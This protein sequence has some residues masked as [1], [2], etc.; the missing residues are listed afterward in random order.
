QVL[1]QRMTSCMQTSRYG[2]KLD[3]S[4]VALYI[5]LGYDP[6][7]RTQGMNASLMETLCL[8]CQV[9]YVSLK[10]A[11]VVDVL[12]GPCHVRRLCKSKIW[13]PWESWKK[14]HEFL[15]ERVD[16]RD[17]IP[18]SVAENPAECNCILCHYEIG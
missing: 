15:L 14:L 3:L 9:A 2:K 6:Y 17:P 10:S 18:I 7:E 13:L 16:I 5:A 8:H 12:I 11:S 1:S 4:L